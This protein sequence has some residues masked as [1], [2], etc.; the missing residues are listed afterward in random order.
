MEKP[1]S[2]QY[3][4]PQHPHS[5]QYGGTGTTQWRGRNDDYLS[6]HD[7]Q[8][9]RHDDQIPEDPKER[10]RR[11]FRYTLSIREEKNVG[12]RFFQNLKVFLLDCWLDIITVLIT[13]AVA[14]AVRPLSVTGIYHR[15]N[16]KGQTLITS[17]MGGTAHP[18]SIIP[19]HIL[20]FRRYSLPPIRLSIRRT[21]ILCRRSRS[22]RWFRT[23]RSHPHCP[24]LGTKLFRFFPCDPRSRLFVGDGDLVSGGFEKDYWGVET[25]F[26]DGL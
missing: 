6:H 9:E 21:D 5:S 18:R 17:G 25:S 12:K 22:R 7:Q 20:H 2:S 4:Q 11:H 14:A 13:I 23:I 10:W 24:N 26:L 1:Q 8:Q 19:N 15:T 16:D 3:F